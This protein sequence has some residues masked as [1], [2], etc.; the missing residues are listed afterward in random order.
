MPPRCRS[1]SPTTGAGLIEI[2]TALEECEV[3]IVLVD[4]DVFHSVP[5]AGRADKQV[6]DTRGI[7]PDQP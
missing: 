2:D 5:L 3:L 6:Y 1:S 7:W 4:H